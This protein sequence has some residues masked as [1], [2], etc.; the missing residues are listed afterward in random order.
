MNAI[1]C[2]CLAVLGL[3][4]A[5]AVRAA[6]EPG[7]R[8]LFDGATLAGWD[9]DPQFWRVE[10]GAIVGETTAEKQPA[11]RK[12][13]FLI[14]RG[15]AF[16][17]FEL[18]FRY[19]VEGYNSG[20]QY[21]SVDRGQWHVSGLQAD[22]KARWHTDRDRP[23]RAPFDRF[24][25]MFFEEGGRMFMAQRGEAVIVR[26]NPDDPKKPRLELIGSL[27]DPAELELAIR[28]DDWND[29][30]VIARGNV[31]LHLINGRVMAAAV[32]ED[33]RHFRRAGLFAFQLHSGRPMKIRVKDIRVRE[34]P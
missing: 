34:L 11:D 5:P 24:S 32:D 25:G 7:F 18:R 14:H 17:D 15:G 12:N 10:A 27:G 3:L 33:E 23:E 9:G 20:V 26:A 31:F 8:P 28:R 13:T 6:A 4:A 19:Q 16:G 29:Y 30:A 1:P 21:R 2:L 22:F